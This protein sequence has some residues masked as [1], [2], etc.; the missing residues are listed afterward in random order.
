M[1]ALC[2][3]L[4]RGTCR[5][6][7]RLRFEA[8][9]SLI[10]TFGIHYIQ[11][12]PREAQSDDL[13]RDLGEIFATCARDLWTLPRQHVHASLSYAADASSLLAS[14]SQEHPQSLQITGD[15]QSALDDA[16]SL[17]R[18]PWLV[19]WIVTFHEAVLLSEELALIHPALYCCLPQLHI[20]GHI[21]AAM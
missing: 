3:V 6:N 13:Y 5:Q 8:Y 19:T 21:L 4:R 20:I 1:R 7:H 15:L 18:I 17:R 16:M 12:P 14:L 2:S 9:F 11:Y 10:K